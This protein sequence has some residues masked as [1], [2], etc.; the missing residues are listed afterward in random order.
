MAQAYAGEDKREFLRHTYENPVRYKVLKVDQGKGKAAKFADAVSKNLSASGILFSAKEMPRISSLLV[1]D[2]D[3]KVTRICQ[4]IEENALVIDDKVF[5]KVVRI[6]D[7]GSGF[8]DIGVAFVKK[9]DDIAKDIKEFM[10]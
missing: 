9:F 1:L 10:I 3:Y 8:Y 4:E 2:L 7:N 6:E 5:G